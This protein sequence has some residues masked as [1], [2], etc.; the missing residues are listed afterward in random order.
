MKINENRDQVD[1]VLISVKGAGDQNSNAN[2]KDSDKRDQEDSGKEKLESL[3]PQT[4]F[5]P[6]DD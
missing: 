5:I 4:P 2:L 1:D 6:V 3:I